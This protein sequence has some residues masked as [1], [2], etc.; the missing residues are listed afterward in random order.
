M[1][2]SFFAPIHNM[3]L[4]SIKNKGKKILLGKHSGRVTND[5][6]WFKDILKDSE[7]SARIGFFSGREFLDSNKTYIYV[8]GKIPSVTNLE[9]MNEKGVGYTFYLLREIEEFI[10]YLWAVKDNNIYVRDGF[11]VAHDKNGKNL[12]AYKASLSAI[13]SFADVR[14]EENTIFSDIEIDRALNFRKSNLFDYSEQSEDE[15]E[16]ENIDYYL[17]YKY[18]TSDIFYSH[19]GSTRLGRAFFFSLNA[20]NSGAVPMKIMFYINALE[21]LFTS[22]N[23]ELSHRVSE[24]VALLLGQN[25]EERMALYSRVKKAYGIRSKVVHGLAFSK[26]DQSLE[27][28]SIHMDNMIRSLLTE[29]GSFFNS[30]DVDLDK[31]FLELLFTSKTN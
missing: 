29:Y 31:K 13:F 17:E 3:E 15:I 28:L 11:L 19:K 4:D 27:E 9:E 5:N 26:K 10:H 16:K 7:I 24:R 25:L 30:N 23:T 22:G 2:F 20:R 1:E 8:N 14:T 18:P 12:S 6:K 21:C